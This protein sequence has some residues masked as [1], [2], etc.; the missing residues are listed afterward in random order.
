MERKL[1][2]LGIFFIVFLVLFVLRTIKGVVHRK[3][4]ILSL[5]TYHKGVQ[6]LYKFLCSIEQKTR[7]FKIVINQSVLGHH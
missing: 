3:I 2:S 6:K 4:K 5:F 7:F 1:K